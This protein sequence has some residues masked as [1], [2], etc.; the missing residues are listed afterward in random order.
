MDIV[1][2]RFSGPTEITI[3]DCDSLNNT[4]VAGVSPAF[5]IDFHPEKFFRIKTT[6]SKRDSETA[7][8]AIMGAFYHAFA[9]QGAHAILDF[10]FVCQINTWWRANFQ[11]VTNFKITRSSEAIADS[12]GLGFFVVEL[13]LRRGRPPRLRYWRLHPP[14]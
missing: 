1:F 13:F 11:A 2:C 6:F 14:E 4:V 9:N 12:V 10:N 5:K 7:F 3:R 8:A